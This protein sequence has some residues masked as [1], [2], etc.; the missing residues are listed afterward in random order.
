MAF[1]RA[2]AVVALEA[3]VAISCLK[4]WT[5]TIN[6]LFIFQDDDDNPREREASAESLPKSPT[7]SSKSKKINADNYLKMLQEQ[8][9][10]QDEEALM[11]QRFE[12]MAMEQQEMLISARKNEMDEQFYASEDEVSYWGLLQVY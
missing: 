11:E 10:K 6:R 5:S 12:R 7:K 1:C 4:H 9:R 3:R 8:Q 2:S